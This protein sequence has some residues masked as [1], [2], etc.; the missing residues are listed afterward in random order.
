MVGMTRCSLVLPETP[1]W[2]QCGVSAGPVVP[3]G[4]PLP[5]GD[6][7]LGRGCGPQAGLGTEWAKPVGLNSNA[8]HL[9][10]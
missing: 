9:Q 3:G 10:I 1:L 4:P 8:Q 6:A 2:L 5:S 7:S